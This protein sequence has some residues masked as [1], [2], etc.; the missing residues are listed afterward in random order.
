M[1]CLPRLHNNSSP[2]PGPLFDNGNDPAAYQTSD[3]TTLCP[4]S[5][6]VSAISLS[7]LGDQSQP[8]AKAS[9]NHPYPKSSCSIVKFFDKNFLTINCTWFAI[10]VVYW[11][12]C[13]SPIGT[14]WG[15]FL[16]ECVYMYGIWWR[17]CPFPDVQYN[18]FCQS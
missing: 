11:L 10:Y 8:V 5:A 4:N 7:P 15:V 16:F 18:S 2:I 1:I 12:Q 14:V 13:F 3:S 9:P 6:T 17:L